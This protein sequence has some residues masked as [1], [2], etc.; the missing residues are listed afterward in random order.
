MLTASPAGGDRAA[1][2]WASVSKRSH[3]GKAAYAAAGSLRWRSGLALDLTLAREFY[4]VIALAIV[5]GVAITFLHFDPIRAPYW[6]AVI[7]GV[8]AV[9][10]MVVTMLMAQSRRV[11]GQFTVRG[12]LAWGGWLATLAMAIAAVGVFVPG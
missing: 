10:I 8:T 11:M 5:G 2:Q 1:F 6:S 3:I 9:P 4:A 7:N 12:W